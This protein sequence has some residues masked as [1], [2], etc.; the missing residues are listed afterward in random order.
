MN[1]KK[2]IGAL[3]FLAF[4]SF[5]AFA[6]NS[7]IL[8]KWKTVDDETGKE[9][10]YLEIYEQG[11][12]VYGKIVK[13]LL[14]EDK[15]KKCTACKGAKKNKPIEGM[16]ILTD[17]ERVDDGWDEGEIMDPKNGKSYSCYI[18]LNGKDKLTVKGYIGFRALGRTQTWH[19]LN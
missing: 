4:V 5:G 13:L 7:S 17:M 1:F 3:A 8:G 2:A 11:G 15:G 16:T 10:S 14:P 6:Q 12:K 9:K 19:R 18:K